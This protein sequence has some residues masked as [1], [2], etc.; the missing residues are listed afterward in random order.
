MAGAL[1]R[2]ASRGCCG[3][4]TRTSRR[5]DRMQEESPATLPCDVDTPTPEA[6]FLH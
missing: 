5:S 1:T 2:I 4:G 6:S 3:R